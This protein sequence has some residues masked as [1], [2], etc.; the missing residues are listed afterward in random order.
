VPPVDAPP[1]VPPL[2]WPPVDVVPP[3]G[4]APPLPTA[5]PDEALFPPLPDD[6][7]VDAEHPA[8]RATAQTTMRREKP[9][10]VTREP[11][12]LGAAKRRVHAHL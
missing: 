6:P 10:F 3:V 5:P 8:A 2:A 4:V 11:S 9:F 12:T 7:P 1:G